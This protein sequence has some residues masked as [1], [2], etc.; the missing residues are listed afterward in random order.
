MKHLFTLNTDF[1]WTIESEDGSTGLA[2]GSDLANR[3]KLY[4]TS[5]KKTEYRKDVTCD[6]SWGIFHGRLHVYVV[7][8]RI[9]DVMI[10]EPN[11]SIP[12]IEKVGRFVLE[13]PVNEQAG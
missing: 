13:D 1:N 6:T 8:N 2:T 4:S 11:S 3:M 5:G 7:D 10:R 9:A 12:I